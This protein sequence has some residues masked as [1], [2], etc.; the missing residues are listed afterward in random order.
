MAK[1]NL[2]GLKAVLAEIPEVQAA[3]QTI[4]TTVTGSEDRSKW[5]FAE[6]QEKAPEAFIELLEKEPAKA[7]ALA[8]AHYK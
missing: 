4:E 7:K 3:S 6:Y 1:T 8:D 2:S 5:T